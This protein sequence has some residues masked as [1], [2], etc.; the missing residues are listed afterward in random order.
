MTANPKATLNHVAAPFEC[1]FVLICF[2]HVLATSGLPSYWSMAF[3]VVVGTCRS[4][5]SSLRIDTDVR[6][7][8]PQCTA[9]RT[10]LQPE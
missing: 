10:S 5:L 1:L 8:V 6:R 4:T 2:P 7:R 3:N 9:A